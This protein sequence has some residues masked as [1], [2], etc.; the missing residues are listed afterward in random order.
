MFSVNRPP[1]PDPR[2][3][4]L[5]HLWFQPYGVDRIVL[6]RGPLLIMTVTPLHFPVFPFIFSKYLCYLSLMVSQQGGQGQHYS[7][8]YFVGK[9][10]C[11]LLNQSAKDVISFHS[12][13]P[14]LLFSCCSGF[15]LSSFSSASLSCH[16]QVFPSLATVR[17]VMFS[18]ISCP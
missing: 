7:P 13:F 15:H 12:A 9:L 17:A 16:G 2:K 8:N 3:R 4:D 18:L 11:P 6:S 1:H 14:V 5:T 10:E